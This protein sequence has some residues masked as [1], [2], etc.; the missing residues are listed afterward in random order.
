MINTWELN[1]PKASK[2]TLRV[3]MKKFKVRA[4]EIIYADDQENNL[5][6]ARQMGIKTILV[7]NYNHFLRELKKLLEKN[8]T[9]N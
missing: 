9:N 7:K 6:D 4:E 1:L 3:V 8:P 2:K 5:I